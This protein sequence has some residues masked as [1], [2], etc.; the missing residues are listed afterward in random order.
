MS[1]PST[2]SPHETELREPPRPHG[3]R[4]FRDYIETLLMPEFRPI[5]GSVLV[6]LIVGTVIFNHFENWGWIDSLYFS[7]VTLATV[8][9]GDLTPTTDTAK[10]FS[11]LYI[12]VGV[13]ILGVFIS[14]ISHASMQRTL[15]RKEQYANRKAAARDKQLE[16]DLE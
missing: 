10:L 13:G 1:D 8:G 9:Y 11:I 14:T 3:L 16:H 7:V 12:F 6:V 15:E 2:S 5:F 4:V